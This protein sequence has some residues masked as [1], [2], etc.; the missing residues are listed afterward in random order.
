LLPFGLA[1]TYSVVNPSPY[2]PGATVFGLQGGFQIIF[3]KFI[4]A[5]MIEGE[6]MS[7]QVGLE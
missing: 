4:E 1:Q 7:T 5:A 6:M 2:Q 3:S